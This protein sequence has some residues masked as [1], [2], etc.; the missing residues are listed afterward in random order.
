[1]IAIRA[2]VPIG[3]VRMVV[4]GF[5]SGPKSEELEDPHPLA[6]TDPDLFKYPYIY[7]VEV[8]QMELNA[9]EAARLREYLFGAASGMLT[10]LGTG[11]IIPSIPRSSPA[12]PTAWA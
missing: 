5:G 7:A 10:I 12:T 1:M 2:A 6:V 9:Q 8:G 11:W 3:L 4:P